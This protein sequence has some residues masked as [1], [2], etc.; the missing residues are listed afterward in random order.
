MQPVE[1]W[2]DM[3]T[4]SNQVAVTPV[5]G[6]EQPIRDVSTGVSAR[7]VVRAAWDALGSMPFAVAILFVVAVAASTGSLIEQNQPQAVYVSR[8]GELQ[9][10]LFRSLGLADVFHAGWFL[11]LLLFLT[12]STGIC[13]WR[14]TPKMLRQFFDFKE[15]ASYSQVAR[16]PGARV[17][18]ADDPDRSVKAAL[19]TLRK[20]G[21]ATKATENSFGVS[22]SAKRGRYRR[23]GY[24]L[25][26]SAIVFV[27]VGG[28]IDANPGLMWRM[29][30][31]TTHP[32]DAALPIHEALTKP[33][34]M[35]V[36]GAFR[37][38]VTVAPGTR[39]E[40]AVLPASEGYL[41]RKLPYTLSL[42]SFHIE[43]HPS[44]QPKDFISEISV[45]DPAT[46]QKLKDLRVGVNAPAAFGGVQ[47]Y[48]S[49]MDD[50]GTE[51]KGVVLSPRA[52]GPVNIEGRVGEEIPLLV[53]GQPYT[54]VAT[55][56]KPKNV[57]PLEEPT[58]KSVR[59]AFLSGP[60]KSKTA[61]VG[62]SV[63]LRLRD[64]AGQEIALTTY[65]RPQDSGDRQSLVT[66]IER[67]NQAQVWVRLPLG[68]DGSL[69]H[70]SA[71]IEALSMPEK[72][73]ELARQL[74]GERR[75]PVALEI[76]GQALDQ[77]ATQF[78]V[79]GGRALESRSAAE[80]IAKAALLAAKQADPQAPLD[81]LLGFSVDALSAYDAWHE[82]GTPPMV[83]VTQ[84][85]PKTATVLQ[86]TYSP[87]APLVYGG[88]LMLC[89]GAALMVLQQERHVWIR[90][91]RQ[92][93]RLVIGWLQTNAGKGSG[94]VPTS[95]VRELIA[96]VT[97]GRH[98]GV[99]SDPI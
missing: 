61:D 82:A 54:V 20:Q 63:G 90:G 85:N 19:S 29:W 33:Q 30:T 26:H 55:S 98:Q 17:H 81:W 9:A 37:G 71:V 50:G 25:T 35:E 38:A 57:V 48:Q 52:A 45:I 22:V 97:H 67:A 79:E 62:P 80:L 2:T 94:L 11:L 59:T 15:R 58:A 43:Y 72:R 96:A 28:L 18:H 5:P 88:M 24:I 12:V 95:D 36:R 65:T 27:S 70:Y 92:G 31:G 16:L 7:G 93:R 86:A 60:S 39:A 87:G 74:V 78:L 14:N 23:I 8:Y 75:D 68:R 34:P 1:R 10:A 89:I 84:A 21:Y 40:Y 6:D 51:F 83:L 3:G 73:L 47:L 32:H 69:R 44:G 91:D 49:G 4:K 77:A 64:S 76:V 42:N 41:L 56:Y 99:L 66:V 46:G 13:V 53:D